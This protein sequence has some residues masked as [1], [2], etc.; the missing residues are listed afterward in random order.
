M[1][2]QFIERKYN[3]LRISLFNLLTY[4]KR[5][6]E[7]YVIYSRFISF[8]VNKYPVIYQIF[9]YKGRVYTVRKKNEKKQL[10]SN[11]ILIIGLSNYYKFK[12]IKFIINE[13]F[14][15]KNRIYSYLIYLE[16]LILSIIKNM[17]DFHQFYTYSVNILF[18]ENDEYENKLHSK[19]NN[20]KHNYF[21]KLYE[22]N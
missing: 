11:T 1:V 12:A 16:R 20:F 10:P 7:F 3:L 17:N 19:F 13:V 4:Y 21:S 14:E 22:I 15:Y 8:V 5:V 2:F 6:Y 18:Y 9:T